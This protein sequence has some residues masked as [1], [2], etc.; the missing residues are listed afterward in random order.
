MNSRDCFE[1][2]RRIRVRGKVQGVYFRA[3]A[4]ERAIALSLCGCAEN[5]RDGSVLV[6]AAGSPASLAKLIA[7]LQVGPPMARVDAVEV[8]DIDPATQEWPAGFQQR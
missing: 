4:A 6:L 2:A 1:A 5:L 7:W 8:E 3:S